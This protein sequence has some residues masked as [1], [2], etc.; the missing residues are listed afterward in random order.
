MALVL[1]H[2]ISG[3]QEACK[4]DGTEVSAAI[5]E[6]VAVIAATGFYAG[7]AIMKHGDLDGEEVDVGFDSE[8]EWSNSI[9][10]IVASLNLK[11]GPPVS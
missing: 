3:F 6:C 1:P 8:E 7:A 9:R 4:S 5:I 10:E 2:M 11:D